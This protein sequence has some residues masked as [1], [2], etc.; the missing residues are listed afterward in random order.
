MRQYTKQELKAIKDESY[1]LTISYDDSMEQYKRNCAGAFLRG[2]I[3]TIITMDNMIDGTN[4][5][6]ESAWNA[7]H[8]S[9][10]FDVGWYLRNCESLQRGENNG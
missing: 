5:D 9:L 4:G 2:T 3:D 10:M 6:Y 1:E 8:D 7:L